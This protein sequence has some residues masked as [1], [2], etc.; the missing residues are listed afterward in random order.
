MRPSPRGGGGNLASDIRL[1]GKHVMFYHA[2]P[3][4]AKIMLTAAPSDDPIRS[5]L[6][7]FGLTDL[8]GVVGSLMICSGYFAVSTGRMQGETLS[9]QLLNAIGA[10]L[11]LVSLYF[12]PNPGAIVIEALWLVIA[13]A[14]IV[15]IVRRR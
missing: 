8:I 9:Y 4:K 6:T 10:I 15:R 13:V 1:G 7:D 14:T 5:A 3:S 12:R 2:R 11:L